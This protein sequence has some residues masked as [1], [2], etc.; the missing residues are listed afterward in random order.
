MLR[1]TNNY[2]F[3]LVDDAALL[4]QRSIIQIDVLEDVD[5]REGQA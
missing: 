2:I 3:A 5:R 4:H 1:L